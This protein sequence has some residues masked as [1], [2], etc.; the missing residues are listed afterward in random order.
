MDPQHSPEPVNRLCQKCFSPFGAGLEHKCGK[1][2]AVD[3]CGKGVAVANLL[4][5]AIISLGSF[6]LDQVAAGI[7]KKRMERDI[8]VDGSETEFFLSTG[9]NPLRVQVGTPDNKAS[10][11]RTVSQISVQ[12][13]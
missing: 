5:L 4:L 7:L 13:I 6:Q 8:L 10:R 3:K 11:R 1:G 9:G 12:G 2:V